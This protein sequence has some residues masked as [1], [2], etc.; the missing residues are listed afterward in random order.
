[1][2][3]ITKKK[4]NTHRVKCVC[5]AFDC[6]LG[7]YV[8]ANGVTQVGV[9]V[10]PA[11]LMA[12]ELA[13]KVNEATSSTSAEQD[14][15]TSHNARNRSPSQASLIGSIAR[16]RLKEKNPQSQSSGS[17]P[18]SQQPIGTFEAH[19]TGLTPSNQDVHPLESG[20]RGTPPELDTGTASREP[21]PGDQ[22]TSSVLSKMC[23]DSTS[24]KAAGVQVYNCGEVFFW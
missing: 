5:R 17:N 22:N 12:H 23:L 7:R 14:I 16:L 4:N 20:L 1:M 13:D 21:Y 19:R 6:Y 8:D 18:M 9:E 11:T 3:P 2:S 24:A 15:P 10:L